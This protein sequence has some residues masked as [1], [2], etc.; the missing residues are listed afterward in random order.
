M[1]FALLTCPLCGHSKA[2]DAA[3]LPSRQATVTCPKCKG[4]FPLERAGLEDPASDFS[5]FEPAS[6]PQPPSADFSPA[7][8]DDPFRSMTFRF[9]GNA[10]EYFGIWIVN[11]LL[12][13]VTVGI[14][15]P[16]AKVRKRRYF[17][18]NTLLDDAPFDYL[19]DPLA[20]LKGWFIA[21]LFFA[22]YSFASR[23]SPIAGAVMA[24]VFMALYPWV[25]VRSR[26][27]NL[28]NSSHRNIR[29]SFKRNYR[30]AYVV[31]LGLALLMPFTLGL[32]LPYMLYRQKKFL[33][34][35]TFYGTTAFQFEGS[36]RQYVKICLP[37]LAIVPVLLVAFSGMGL[38]GKVAEKNPV[39][40]IF[41]VLSFIVFYL[42]AVLYLPTAITN[43]TWRATRIAGN[44][45]DCDLKVMRL[46]WLYTTNMIAVICTLGMLMPWAT[47][48]LARYRLS[49][50][51]LAGCGA[52]DKISG[53]SEEELS[54]TGEELG[55]MLGFDFGL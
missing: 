2:V 42:L 45:F 47:V 4:K 7:P 33:V 8:P 39:A 34:E 36:T 38:L 28:R 11:T 29:F 9:T 31:F 3:H 24:V 41:P 44:A 53:A 14:Y 20:I 55:D 32:M 49:V 15:S 21:C 37:L 27:L 22:L 10:K 12:R 54:A 25:L 51:S 40:V 48:R 13:V 17:Y 1:P 30:E 16:W 46:A 23:T 26:A 52:L 19:A 6:A 18:A 50:M 5:I 43:T 35:N